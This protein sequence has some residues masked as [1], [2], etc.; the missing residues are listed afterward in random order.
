MAPA[1]VTGAG[2]TSVL[3]WKA[4]A[5]ALYSFDFGYTAGAKA[6]DANS[7]GVTVSVATA[8]GKIY[9]KATSKDKVD[10]EATTVYAN[11]KKGEYIYFCSD[12]NTNGGNDV[13]SFDVSVNK[14]GYYVDNVKSFRFGGEAYKAVP[15]QD[16]TAQEQNGWYYMWSPQT[17]MA[18]VMDVSKIKECVASD[19]GSCWFA[20]GGGALNGG[21]SGWIPDIYTGDT[22]D[23]WANNNWWQQMPDGTM[24]PAVVTGAGASSVLGWKAQSDGHYLIEFRYTAGAKAVDANS[25]GVTISIATAAGNLYTKTTS[26]DKIDTG[27]RMIVVNLKAGEYIYFMSDPNTNGGNDVTSFDIS[28]HNLK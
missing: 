6:V 25:D 4:P 5:A 9:A 23:C 21:Y 8:A 18:G 15:G 16:G 7:D 12:P 2:A 10:T 3:G 1:V 26:K 19:A 13:T 28:V 20:Y 17:N 11:L 14:A 22:Y 27:L 24:A